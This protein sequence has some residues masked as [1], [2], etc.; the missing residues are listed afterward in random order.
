MRDNNQIEISE[1]RVP[2][3]AGKQIGERFRALLNYEAIEKTKSYTM[4]R[5]KYIS[6]VQTKRAF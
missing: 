4:V 3:L 2:G 1:N 5:V 6:I